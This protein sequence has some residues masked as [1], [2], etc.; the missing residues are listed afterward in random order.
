[1][2]KAVSRALV[3]FWGGPKD[4]EVRVL[5]ETPYTI[6]YP[7]YDAP[8]VDAPPSQYLV[9]SVVVYRREAT[10]NGRWRYVFVE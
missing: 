2:A 7:V 5:E 8:P 4:G 9:Y 10:T 3:T 1:M 6:K